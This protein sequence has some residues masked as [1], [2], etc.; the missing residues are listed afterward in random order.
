MAH[1]S[2]SADGNASARC[3][4]TGEMPDRSVIAN[5]TLLNLFSE[6]QYFLDIRIV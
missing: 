5:I 1:P 6:Y 3:F 2:E 4:A